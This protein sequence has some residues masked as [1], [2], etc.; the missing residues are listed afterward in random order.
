MF[1]VLPPDEDP[2]EPPEE[3]DPPPDPELLEELPHAA[4][5]RTDTA[6]IDHAV[7]RRKNP[8]ATAVPSL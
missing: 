5:A 6:V 2:P 3:P 7:H 1:S 4:K 8:S